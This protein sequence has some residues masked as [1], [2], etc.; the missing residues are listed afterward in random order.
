MTTFDLHSS[1][2]AIVLP[3]ILAICMVLLF[4]LGIYYFKKKS[5]K[6]FPSIAISL[7]FTVA[8]AYISFPT[9]FSCRASYRLDKF[10]ALNLTKEE[11]ATLAT[12]ERFCPLYYTFIRNGKKECIEGEHKLIMGCA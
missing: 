1:T 8:I 5:V 9:Y 4:F 3:I 6:A 10:I 2:S 11:I 7:V 12:E